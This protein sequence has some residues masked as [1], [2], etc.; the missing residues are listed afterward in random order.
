MEACFSY[1]HEFKVNTTSSAKQFHSN[2]YVNQLTEFLL[3]YKEFIFALVSENILVKICINLLAKGLNTIVSV[4][5]YKNL[6]K[7]KTE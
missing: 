6:S 3:G 1:W 7:I 4:I 2:C 5:K